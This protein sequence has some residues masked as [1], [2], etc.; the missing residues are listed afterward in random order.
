MSLDRLREPDQ[1]FV[2]AHRGYVAWDDR[3]YR[4]YEI[5]LDVGHRI[6]SGESRHHKADQ[7]MS[8]F[9]AALARPNL[10]GPTQR[11]AEQHFPGHLKGQ[12]IHCGAGSFPTLLMPRENGAFRPLQRPGGFVIRCR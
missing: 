11:G 12:K 3:G 1:A 10:C 7:R 6:T 9:R 2:V 5:D 8:L 4:P